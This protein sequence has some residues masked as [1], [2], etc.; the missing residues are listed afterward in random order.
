MVKIIL[1]DLRFN[2]LKLNDTFLYNMMKK[3]VTLVIVSLLFIS[4][5]EV[6]KEYYPSGKV[7]SETEM[8]GGK[9]HGTV[10]VYHEKT[11]PIMMKYQM[12]NGVKD[13]SFEKFYFDGS[14][15][16]QAFYVDGKLEG[17]EVMFDKDGGI[18][19]EANYKNGLKDGPY[20]T[21]H[22]KGMLKEKGAFKN[23]LWEGEWLYYDENGMIVGDATFTGGTG[24][25]HA[26]NE[27]GNLVLSTEYVANV[28]NG[29]EISFANNGDTLK[30]VIFENNKIVEVDGEKIE[31]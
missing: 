11:H 15:E 22:S 31:R 30:E 16:Y 17:K 23:D 12:K 14:C 1:L 8:K 28:K 10:I 21:Y 2:K 24:A 13:G 3:I 18:V 19:Y 27:N 5:T 20:S 25:L 26:Y 29:K 7:K 4:C 6:K 9:E